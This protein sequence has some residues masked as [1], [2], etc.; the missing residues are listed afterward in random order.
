MA[1]PN[2]CGMLAVIL[3]I[4]PYLQSK[5]QLLDFMQ[6]HGLL[7]KLDETAT[8]AWNYPNDLGQTRS[9]NG[10]AN[11]ISNM[12]FANHYLSPTPSAETAQAKASDISDVNIQGPVTIKHS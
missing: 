4:R 11:M 3:G 6:K 7:N 10:S 8:R 12:P 2:A 9:L 5:E 1:S